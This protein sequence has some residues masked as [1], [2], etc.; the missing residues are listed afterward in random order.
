M[1]E[2]VAVNMLAYNHEKWIERA[3][4]GV[5]NQKTN[6]PFKLYI[7]DDASTDKTAQIIKEY[8]DKYPDM[9]VAV[10]EKENQHSKG[11][12]ISRSIMFPLMD[13]EYI[14]Y[15]EGDDYWIDDKKLQKQV[16][17][18]DTHK[19]CTYSF[20]NAILV[21][22]VNKKRGVFLPSGIWNDKEINNKLKI[23]SGCDF[24][25]EE[26]IMLDMTPTATI[27]MRSDTYRKLNNFSTSLDLLMRL[28]STHDGY[29]HYHNEC[30]AA[31]RTGNS[32]SASGK[33]MK[34][35]VN[36]RKCVYEIHKEIY[37]EFD[38]Y[39]DYRYHKILDHELKRKELTL[40]LNAPDSDKKHICKM[41]CYKELTLYR[42]VKYRIEL[43]FPKLFYNLKKIKHG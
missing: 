12:T 31:Y 26:M 10:L 11:V 23:G 42:R 21:D 34:S 39:T 43:Y 6:F 37:E 18:M 19:K 22:T 24:T 41:E 38:N 15:C 28:V 8:A 3:I 7:H 32:N 9:I 20:S 2:K 13:C 27:L 29:A 16:D 25:A 14:A 1:S 4:L 40:Y 5:I 36:M 30:F 33:A 35:F 17:Y